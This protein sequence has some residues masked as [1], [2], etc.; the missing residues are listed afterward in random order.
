MKKFVL[1]FLVGLAIGT[2]WVAAAFMS[3]Q[4][5]TDMECAMLHGED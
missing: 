3:D 2:A 5:I 4:C 1:G